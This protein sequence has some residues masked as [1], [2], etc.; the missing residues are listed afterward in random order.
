MQMN[1]S[2]STFVRLGYGLVAVIYW[3]RFIVGF[4]GLL[5]MFVSALLFYFGFISITFAIFNIAFVTIINFCILI[6]AIKNEKH[7]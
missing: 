5:V 2:I 4:L 7:K 6:I 3:I 1:K